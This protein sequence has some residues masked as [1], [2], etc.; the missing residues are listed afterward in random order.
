M[1][2]WRWTKIK[3]SK[4]VGQWNCT[5]NVIELYILS[6]SEYKVKIYGM[7]NIKFKYTSFYFLTFF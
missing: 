4:R 3:G 2:P 5:I 7:N 6:D 1:S